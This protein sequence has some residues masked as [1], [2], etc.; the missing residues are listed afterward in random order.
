MSE[1]LPGSWHAE[2]D[3]RV[4]LLEAIFENKSANTPEIVNNSVQLLG[5]SVPTTQV[6]QALVSTAN[7]H[8]QC[9]I[10]HGLMEQ[11]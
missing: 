8:S 9:L 11:A 10:E 1:H 2:I 4:E 5:V 3:G 6:M 7:A